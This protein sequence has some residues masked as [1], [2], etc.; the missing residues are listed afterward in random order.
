MRKL[1]YK[2]GTFIISFRGKDMKGKCMSSLHLLSAPERGHPFPLSRNNANAHTA[3]KLFYLRLFLDWD[4][5]TQVK[6]LLLIICPRL[7]LDKGKGPGL[8]SIL[9][10][11]RR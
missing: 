11:E 7:H 1:T 9:T 10:P 2:T 4:R 8:I 6:K 5:C 3:E